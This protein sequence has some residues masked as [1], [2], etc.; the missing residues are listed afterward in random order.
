MHGNSG[1][2]HGF[3]WG[4]IGH[5]QFNKLHLIQLSDIFGI[6]GVSFLIALAN[7]TIFQAFRYITGSKWK[8][9]WDG[10]VCG[11]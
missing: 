4:L 5:S 11:K 6:Y 2:F 3:P 7:A 9:V 10:R 8:E 1:L